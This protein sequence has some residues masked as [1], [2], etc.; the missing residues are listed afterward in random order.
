M[1]RAARRIVSFLPSATEMIYALGLEESLFGVTHECDWPIDA[2][3]KPVVVTSVLPTQEMSQKEIDEAVSARLKGGESLYSVDEAL[4]RQ[5]APDLIVTQNLCQVCA[6]SGNEV[7]R[8][9]A[10][11]V[12]KPEVLYLTPRT[13]DEI[14]DNVRTLGEATGSSKRA[15]ALIADGRSKLA[16]IEA[17]TRGARRL[18]V[19]CMEWLD[20][21][22]CCGHWVPEMVRIAGGI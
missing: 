10:S 18:R 21:V 6:P 7:T 14:F 13:I 2:Q 12:T 11:L 15:D 3:R 4:M 17:R 22:Y 5:I 20:P 8:L 19:F 16:R 9:L 1:T